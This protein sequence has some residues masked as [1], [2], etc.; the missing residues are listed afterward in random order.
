MGPTL[1]LM[2]IYILCMRNEEVTPGLLVILMHFS[3]RCGISKGR[4]LPFPLVDAAKLQCLPVFTPP[5]T[6]QDGAILPFIYLFIDLIYSNEATA[7]LVSRLR[8]DISS[9]PPRRQVPGIPTTDVS[10]FFLTCLLLIFPTL[11][12]EMFSFQPQPTR[13]HIGPV[14]RPCGLIGWF[15]KTWFHCK[16]SRRPFH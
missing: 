3:L 8:S 2:C 5:V 7:C 9:A 10:L 13:T 16:Q 1:D 12:F 4:Q 11:C 14:R 6:C 15:R